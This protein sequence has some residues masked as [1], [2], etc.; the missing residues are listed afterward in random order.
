[1]RNEDTPWAALPHADQ[2]SGAASA[3]E[4]PDSEES[5]TAP[6]RPGVSVI[7]E[8]DFARVIGPG[9]RGPPRAGASGAGAR[10]SE[11]GREDGEGGEDGESVSQGSGAASAVSAVEPEPS[12]RDES[13]VLRRVGAYLAMAGKRARAID[14]GAQRARA[15]GRGRGRGGL[16]AS[17][18]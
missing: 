10:G 18:R 15:R 7:P 2:G 5:G 17:R 11:D 12:A 1:M 14:R 8:A 3:A 16:G 9:Y 13:G 6:L 4:L